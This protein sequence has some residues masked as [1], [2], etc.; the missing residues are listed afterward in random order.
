MNVVAL[1][2]GI[3]LQIRADKLE[4]ERA[5]LL[6]QARTHRLLIASLEQQLATASTQVR[7]AQVLSSSSMSRLF[8]TK[9]NSVVSDEMQRRKHL[10]PHDCESKSCHHV[11]WT[12][13]DIATDIPIVHYGKGEEATATATRS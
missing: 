6:K 12:H 10:V 5:A 13:D 11:S 3:G 8:A 2:G 1:L 9:I 4:A 7:L